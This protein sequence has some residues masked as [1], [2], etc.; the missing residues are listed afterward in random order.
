MHIFFFY[1]CVHIPPEESKLPKILA[2]IFPIHCHTPS[3]WKSAWLSVD[4]K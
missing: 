1:F 4:N 2:I 3:M